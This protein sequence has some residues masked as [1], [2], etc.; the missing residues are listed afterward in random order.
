MER[1]AQLQRK[2]GVISGCEVCVS[3]AHFAC[4]DGLWWLG[5][6]GALVLLGRCKVSPCSEGFGCKSRKSPSRFPVIGLSGSF[7]QWRPSDLC[8]A[9]LER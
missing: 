1:D 5:E 2:G 7:V 6:M 9:S 4:R 8:E 3:A